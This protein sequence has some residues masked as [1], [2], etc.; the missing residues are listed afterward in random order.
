LI[1]EILLYLNFSDLNVLKVNEDLFWRLKILQDLPDLDLDLIV[2]FLSYDR[3][4]LRP[5]T[6]N[7]RRIDNYDVFIVTDELK[8]F[9]DA[10]KLHRG[11]KLNTF[12][13]EHLIELSYLIGIQFSTS[14]LYKAIYYITIFTRETIPADMKFFIHRV[15]IL[16]NGINKITLSNMIEQH[17]NMSDT[18]KI[19]FIL[20]HERFSYM[21]AHH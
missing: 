12:M 7:R 6:I 17:L 16:I 8:V 21:I 18:D 14:N 1:R 2:Q 15:S 13:F 5:I 19:S 3:K 11:Q 20:N 9:N 10:R 4:N